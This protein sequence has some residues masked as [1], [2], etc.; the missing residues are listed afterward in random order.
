MGRSF[1][2][3][4]RATTCRWSFTAPA[5]SPLASSMNA[6]LVRALCSSVSVSARCWL[7]ASRIERCSAIAAGKS[8]SCA[9][10]IAA[11]AFAV[12]TSGASA[13]SFA[14]RTAITV[15]CSANAPAKSPSR[16]RV[17]A[18]CD[19]TARNNGV[20]SSPRCNSTSS[21]CSCRSNAPVG[22]PVCVRSQATLASARRRA[23]FVIGIDCRAASTFA[24]IAEARDQSPR[25]LRV[26]ARL[27][28]ACSA[29][30]WPGDRASAATN[31][32]CTSSA[33]IKSDL[34]RSVSARSSRAATRYGSCSARRARTC[35]ACSSSARAPTRSPHSRRHAAVV[36][37]A[38]HRTGTSDSAPTWAT[39]VA[40]ARSAIGSA[41][42]GSRS[43]N[44]RATLVRITCRY[45]CWSSRMRSI[46]TSACCCR[47]PPDGSPFSSK[48]PARSARRNCSSRS[49]AGSVRSRI[50]SA[51]RSSDRAPA[52]SLLRFLVIASMPRAT[53]RSVASAGSSRSNCPTAAEPIASASSNRPMERSVRA[54]RAR[55]MCRRAS[56]GPNSVASTRSTSRCIVNAGSRAPVATSAIALRLITS[57]RSRSVAGRSATAATSRSSRVASE[58]ALPHARARST[59]TSSCSTAG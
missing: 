2:T 39:N 1:L 23:R 21:T 4:A 9:R 33:P 44:S 38:T 11:S 30:E 31:R 50:S 53:C 47:G 27:L 36:I 12:N 56:S 18:S 42:R 57:R 24:S 5:A 35:T 48:A 22:S 58:V 45:G 34:A 28:C 54:M 46:A 25:R 20:S 55:S 6:R 14:A 17:P 3:S 26:T 51:C 41:A 13:G 40:S 59:A 37:R 15:R 10:L 43:H 29:M 19:C 7:R 32:S 16:L 49:S 52:M 8:R